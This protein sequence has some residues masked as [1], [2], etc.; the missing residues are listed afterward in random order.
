MLSRP[1]P[2]ARA[3]TVAL[4]GILVSSA[5]IAATVDLRVIETTDI[6]SNVVDYDFYKS[7]PTTRFGLVRAATLVKEAQGEAKNS[8]L[9]DNGDLI[10]GSP[11][12][13]WRAAE[14]L[15]EGDI[16]PVY[17]AMNQM[18]YAVANIGNHEFNYGLEYL[19]EAT[20]D[21]NFPYVNA[22]V[23]D[24]KT[25]KHLF[26]P[27]IIKEMQVTDTEGKPQTIKVGFIGFVPPQIMQW[28][29]KN[30]TGKVTVTDITATAREMVPEMKAKGADVVVAI[31]TLRY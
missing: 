21:A 15:K 14:G 20:N 10:Q 30:L 2:L 16:H 13:D 27:Y 18:G 17:K 8:V 1:A 4:T 9:V 28:D 29:R 3:I 25:G 23:R 26:N 11:M 7:K 31:P 24:A 12:G 22:N 6:H 5:T 19:K